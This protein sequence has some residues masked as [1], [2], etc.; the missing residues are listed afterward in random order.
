MNLVF[1]YSLQLACYLTKVIEGSLLP[2]TRLRIFR[3]RRGQRPK[4]LWNGTID[5]LFHEG[6]KLLV[7]LT[8]LNSEHTPHRPKQYKEQS[9]K[10]KRDQDAAMNRRAREQA[11]A[12]RV[13]NDDL[14]H[15]SF[16]TILGNT[17][18]HRLKTICSHSL[19]REHDSEKLSE[20]RRLERP[21]D[22][23]SE[24]AIY[25]RKKPRKLK[26][27][28]DCIEENDLEIYTNVIEEYKRIERDKI[29]QREQDKPKHKRNSITYS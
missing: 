28:I 9:R 1:C 13:Y 14:L 3:V 11:Q 15:K 19:F 20:L 4:S 23:A 27:L 5:E 29:L 10:I 17:G 16:I 24:L 6:E 8:P 2:E 26:E 25:F 7:E 12:E 22:I 21:G 18:E